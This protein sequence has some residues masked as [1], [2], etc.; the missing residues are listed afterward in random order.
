MKQ[1]LN[2]SALVYLEKY[3][4]DFIDH[5]RNVTK[6]LIVDISTLLANGWSGDAADTFQQFYDRMD[7]FHVKMADG[8]ERWDRKL[9]ICSKNGH[10]TVLDVRNRLLKQ[11][12][13]GGV[14]QLTSAVL[15]YEDSVGDNPGDMTKNHLENCND[16]ADR[17]KS[18]ESKSSLNYSYSYDVQPIRKRVE[19]SAQGLVDN[20]YVF[21][22]HEYEK[23][24]NVL[25]TDL[26]EA[27]S[28]LD[29]VYK[30]LKEVEPVVTGAKDPSNPIYRALAFTDN[31]LLA[32][33]GDRQEGRG[34]SN[35]VQ[36]GRTL[37]DDIFCVCGSNIYFGNRRQPA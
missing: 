8:T 23:Y 35:R 37:Q 5:M 4:D 25:R 6:T 19:N 31:I 10:D 24:G 12:D 13:G 18:I 21:A 27:V 2:M 16:I 32:L 3:H 36:R 15:E 20:E 29:A 22:I 14:A 34:L 9:R 7:A 30:D 11:L 1:K 26:T 17:L 33:P 28:E